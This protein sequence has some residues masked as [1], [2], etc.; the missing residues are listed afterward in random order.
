M[1]LQ[2]SWRRA[3]Q[4]VGAALAGLG[5]LFF[6]SPLAA[7]PSVV[8]T[9]KPLHSLVASVMSGIGEPELLITG[10]ASPHGYTL[11]PSDITEL[12]QADLVVWVGASLET[13]LRQVFLDRAERAPT[14]SVLDIPGMVLKPDRRGT[15]WQRHS[16]HGEEDHEGE[17]FEVEVNSRV[18]SDEQSE[19][20]PHLWLDPGNAQTFV[21]AMVDALSRT[22][23]ENARSYARNGRKLHARLGS[24]DR[25]IEAR[26]EPVRGQ[27][28]LVFHDAYQYF[29][30]RYHLSPA[31]SVTVH[32]EAAPTARRLVAIQRLVRGS[33]AKCIFSEPQFKSKMVQTLIQDTGAGHGTLDPIGLDL[34][35]GVDL[36]F[37]LMKNMAASIVDCLG[38]ELSG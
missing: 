33:D 34:T 20:D 28:Y 37:S 29:E 30:H 18:A 38:T 1:N 25:E 7:E 3:R 9:I 27:S 24:I 14:V 19:F 26:L 16:S 6:T 13:G 23:P 15:E 10:A 35:P 2:P 11:R 22:D 32:P 31:G 8:V 4:A 17:S 21:S 12:D 36:Y 5:W